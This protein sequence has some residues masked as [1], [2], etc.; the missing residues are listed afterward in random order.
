MNDGVRTISIYVISNPLNLEL[1]L[2]IRGVKREC[3]ENVTI[4]FC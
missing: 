4:W 1:N 2:Y 3:V